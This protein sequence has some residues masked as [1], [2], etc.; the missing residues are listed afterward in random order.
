MGLCTRTTGSEYTQQ[1]RQ[2]Q[3]QR[4]R[5]RQR[6]DAMRARSGGRMP[7]RGAL[8]AHARTHVQRRPRAHACVHRT[9][10][11]P[12]A[13]RPPARY[14]FPRLLPNVIVPFACSL[15]YSPASMV[16]LHLCLLTAATA[17]GSVCP[18]LSAG[19]YPSK[20]VGDR[21]S[22]RAVCCRSAALEQTVLSIL[23]SPT[24]APISRTSRC[25]QRWITAG[26]GPVQIII[27][28]QG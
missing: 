7:I 19:T 6:W 22:H 25:K 13:S 15:T 12:V 1:Q 26:T 8:H 28:W 27:R 20:V 2:Q 3:R 18:G 14:F 16:S 24:R 9:R 11:S 10:A 23:M 17:A 5:R 4:R 21:W